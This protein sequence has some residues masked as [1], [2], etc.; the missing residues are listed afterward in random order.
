[1]YTLEE[2]DALFNMTD[3][4]YVCEPINQIDIK[5]IAY[6]VGRH[7]PTYKYYSTA[8]YGDTARAAVNKLWEKHVERITDTIHRLRT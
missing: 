4:S 1:M 6:I 8:C 3:T 2:L 5:Y 7:D